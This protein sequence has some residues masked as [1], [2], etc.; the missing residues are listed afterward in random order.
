V[1]KSGRELAA[2]Q[3]AVRI[4]MAMMP[5]SAISSPTGRCFP[6]IF[7]IVSLQTKAPMAQTMRSPARR[8]MFC[9]RR[10]MDDA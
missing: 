10:S 7:T 3:I 6:T 4:A 2:A 8:A 9:G 1:R 5:R